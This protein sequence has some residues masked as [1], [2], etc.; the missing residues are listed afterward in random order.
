MLG[1]SVCPPHP[2]T[3]ILFFWPLFSSVQF[4]LL[5][6]SPQT[7]SWSRLVWGFSFPRVVV[8]LLSG[9][10]CGAEP[11]RLLS[12]PGE[13]GCL[14]LGPSGVH[15]ALSPSRGPVEPALCGPLLRAGRCEFR[16]ARCWASGVPDPLLSRWVLSR[17]LDTKS[18]TLLS[19]TWFRQQRRSRGRDLSACAHCSPP[20]A[21][22]LAGPLAAGTH[23]SAQAGVRRRMPAAHRAVRARRPQ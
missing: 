22:S 4:S 5:S 17:P 10:V 9:N 8:A 23:M 15:S 11:L 3:L 14:A 12:A 7:V 1:Q 20:F 2:L 19:G 16:L 21:G 13:D 6:S 18:C